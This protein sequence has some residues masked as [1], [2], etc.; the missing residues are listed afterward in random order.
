MA[1]INDTL[2]GPHKKALDSIVADFN[3]IQV[4]EAPHIRGQQPDW[5]M[6]LL[7]FDLARADLKSLVP[8]GS[9]PGTSSQNVKG[10]TL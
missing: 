2:L 3:T 5:G 1:D 6:A 8:E 7:I 10:R 9:N 4:K